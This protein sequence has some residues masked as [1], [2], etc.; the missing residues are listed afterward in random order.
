MV[1]HKIVSGRKVGVTHNAALGAVPNTQRYR[2]FKGE[3]TQGRFRLRS[4]AE[5]IV[6]RRC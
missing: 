6:T 1:T 2:Q 4:A 3:I 5:A